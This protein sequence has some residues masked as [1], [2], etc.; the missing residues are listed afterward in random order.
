MSDNGNV[1][2]YA[3]YGEDYA[4]LRFFEEMHGGY[5]VDVGAYD[6]L[7][8]SNT[9]TLALHYGWQGVCIEPNPTTF[10]QLVANRP[11]VLCLP[12]ACVEDPRTQRVTLHV[13][14][15]PLLS[16]LSLA[17]EHEIKR[18]HRDTCIPY[19]IRE[20]V[21]VPAATLDALLPLVGLPYIDF[22][23]ID[24]DWCNPQTLRG[25]NLTRWAP[26]LVVIEANGPEEKEPIAAYMSAHGYTYAGISTNN[27][28]WVRDAEDAERVTGIHE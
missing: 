25:C 19:A 14:N 27:M 8:Q 24:T 17:R 21:D 15:I 10:A 9:A 12:F 6:G 4:L 7:L 1:R 5:Y 3:Q 2:Y 26:R 18:I 28:F 23:S 16:T 13:P 20:T 22:L 11:G